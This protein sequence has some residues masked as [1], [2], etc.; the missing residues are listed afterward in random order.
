MEPGTLL[1]PIKSF[2]VP[3]PWAIT[4]GLLNIAQMTL[5]EKLSKANRWRITSGKV[6]STAED[7]FNGHFLVPLEGD[8]WHLILSDGM[9]WRHLSCT[10]AQ[11][12]ILPNYH[13]MCRLKACFFPDDAWVVQFHPPPDEHVNDHPYCLHLWQ[14]IAGEMPHPSIV[15]V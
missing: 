6:G 15:L 9:G 2:T 12:K 10:N 13:V 1:I 3:G 11:K 8:L 14:Y 4:T 7:G 5:L